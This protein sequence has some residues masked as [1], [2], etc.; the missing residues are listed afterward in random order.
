MQSSKLGTTKPRLCRTSA[1]FCTPRASTGTELHLLTA[2]LPRLT[3]APTSL[4]VYYPCL[5]PYSEQTMQQYSDALHREAPTAEHT[6]QAK[7]L[8]AA[9]SGN[10]AAAYLHNKEYDRVVTYAQKVRCCTH[11]ATKPCRLLLGIPGSVERTDLTCPV[12][13]SR[14]R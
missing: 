11:V 1:C 12:P 4:C 5:G 6:A 2:L 3:C 7:Q 13:G 10:L 8:N 14:L 9:V